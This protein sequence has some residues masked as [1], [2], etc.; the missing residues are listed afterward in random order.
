MVVKIAWRHFPIAFLS[1][2]C[3]ILSYLDRSIISIAILPL[4]DEIGCTTR[5]KGMILGAFYYGYI[6]TQIIGG[7]AARVW[8][9]YRVLAIMVT[10][11][12]CFTAL[13]APSASLV[14]VL[15]LIRICVGLAE[16][17]GHP[18]ILTIASAWFPYME[19]ATSVA[20][21]FGCTY[22]GSTLA[23]VVVPPLVDIMGWRSVFYISGAMGMIWVCAWSIFGSDGPASNR[24]ISNEERDYIVQNLHDTSHSS[25]QMLSSI[26][27]EEEEEE[28]GTLP[29]SRLHADIYDDSNPNIHEH[30]SSHT[31]SLLHSNHVKVDEDDDDERADHDHP[32]QLTYNNQ[33]STDDIIP[34]I[35]TNTDKNNNNNNNKNNTQI[36]EV[37]H[38]VMGIPWRTIMSRKEVWAIIVTNFGSDWGNTILFNWMPS[39]LYEVHH[40]SFDQMMY[41]TPLPYISMFFGSLLAGVAADHMRKRDMPLHRIRKIMNAIGLMGPCT[42]VVI[43]GLWGLLYPSSSSS[44]FASLILMGGFFTLSA[45]QAGYKPNI[46]DVSQQYPGIIYSVSILIHP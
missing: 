44:G 43:L 6:S 40:A 36:Q 13:T 27:Q 35:Q 26:H 20:A 15:V 3:M 30:N 2:V 37:W 41:L 28:Q 18:C 24:F 7:I 22:I 1:G 5:S 21:I 17:F 29:S 11:W 34:N 19:R 14:W 8:G 9:P 10:V 32:S 4:C 16:G 12:S 23:M 33:N 31:Q 25:F 45:V 46:L 38:I 39:Y 42:S